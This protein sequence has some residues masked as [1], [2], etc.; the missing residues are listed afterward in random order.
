VDRRIAMS[1]LF[2][3]FQEP[4]LASRARALAGLPGGTF[5]L[6][7][8][9]FTLYPLLAGVPRWLF[10][11]VRAVLLAGALGGLAGILYLGARGLHESRRG[12]RAG[13]RA[14]LW[15]A[16]DLAFALICGFLLYSMS[17]PTL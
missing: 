9:Y 14:A 16:V 7:Q 10:E 1:T 12:I 8:L 5:L 11:S 17:V 4:D 3:S 2:T 15:L 6:S 13:W